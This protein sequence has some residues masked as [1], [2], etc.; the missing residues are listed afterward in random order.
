MVSSE[1]IATLILSKEQWELSMI[2]EAFSFVLRWKC[3]ASF[4]TNSL[5]R[6]KPTT[7]EQ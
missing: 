2:I 3:H 7:N 4:L 5:N 6:D 1:Y